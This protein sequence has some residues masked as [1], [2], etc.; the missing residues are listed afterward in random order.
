MKD[1]CPDMKNKDRTASSGRN[2]SRIPD[3]PGDPA[4]FFLRPTDFSQRRK[5]GGV[6]LKE[7]IAGWDSEK[8]K[9]K[10]KLKYLEPYDKNGNLTKETKRNPDSSGL[11]LL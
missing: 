4:F 11:P 2:K 9:L 6:I 10:Q 8:K 7:E 5:A 1:D 3:C